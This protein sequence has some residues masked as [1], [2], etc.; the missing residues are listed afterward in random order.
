LIRKCDVVSVNI[1]PPGTIAGEIA[2]PVPPRIIDILEV[3]TLLDDVCILKDVAS[4]PPPAP[5]VSAADSTE[6]C[7][8]AFEKLFR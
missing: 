1:L 5:L 7:I 3:P 6:D 8:F 2:P 4:D